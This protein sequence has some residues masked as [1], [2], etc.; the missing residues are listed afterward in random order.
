MYAEGDNTLAGAGGSKTVDDAE[1][2]QSQKSRRRK[3]TA[4]VWHYVGKRRV[5]TRSASAYIAN[6]G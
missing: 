3:L 6:H 4:N 2:S 1:I 5:A